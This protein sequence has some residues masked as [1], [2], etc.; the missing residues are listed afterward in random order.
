LPV[1]GIF[2]SCSSSSY[3]P[4]TIAM[5]HSPTMS[6]SGQHNITTNLALRL[7]G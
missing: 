5:H 1:I 6:F 3:F 4:A 7:L 2:T